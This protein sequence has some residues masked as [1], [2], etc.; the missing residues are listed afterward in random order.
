MIMAIPYLLSPKYMK[1]HVQLQAIEV[2]VY[3]D[4][5]AVL[6][7]VSTDTINL[8]LKYGHQPHSIPG[9]IKFSILDSEG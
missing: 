1:I 9:D 2:A 6:H 7:F 5:L 3:M 8:E 4:Q